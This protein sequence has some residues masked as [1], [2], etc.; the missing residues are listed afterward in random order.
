MKIAYRLGIGFIILLCLFGAYGLFALDR[1]SALAGLTAKLHNHPHAI[2]NLAVGAE[3]HIL[4]ANRS[5]ERLVSVHGAEKIANLTA[6]IQKH[7]REIAR[8]IESIDN[9]YEGE[10]YVL[11]ELRQT[12]AHWESVVGQIVGRK[13]VGRH[14]DAEALLDR[15]HTERVQDLENTV[16]LLADLAEAEAAETMA[17][18]RKTHEASIGAT[19]SLLFLMCI[20]AGGLFIWLAKSIRRT[21]D[22]A[23]ASTAKAD[24]TTHDALEQ[25]EYLRHSVRGMLEEMDRLTGEAILGRI[26]H[27]SRHAADAVSRSASTIE[28][29]SASNREI[30]QIVKVIGDV[31]DQTNL[32]ALNAAIE[33]ARTGD[34]GRGFGFIA[35]EVRKLSERTTRETKQ[36]EAMVATIQSEI[37]RA[38]KRI[39]AGR[40]QVTEC[41]AMIER[42]DETHRQIRHRAGEIGMLMAQCGHPS[43]AD[44]YVN[45]RQNGNPD[46]IPGGDGAFRLNGRH[47]QPDASPKR[48]V[49]NETSNGE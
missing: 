10:A 15:A 21:L 2:I 39:H 36:I 11:A 5:V 1:M 44:A 7:Q 3:N 28:D 47:P 22:A 38:A 34:H 42:V 40:D 18:A 27:K 37:G 46:G 14:R 23:D 12:H 9:R 33:A 32:L 26:I 17:S 49:L 48:D 35:E 31:A 20:L 24:R 13:E 25:Q 6:E 45:R 41:A 19:V 4:N 8:T 29:L 16:R 43:K 30:G